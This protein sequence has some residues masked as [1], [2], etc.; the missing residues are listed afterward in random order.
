MLPDPTIARKYPNSVPRERIPGLISD[1]REILKEPEVI[2]ALRD[3]QYRVSPEF[4][5]SSVAGRVHDI[6]KAINSSCKRQIEEGGIVRHLYDSTKMLEQLGLITKGGKHFF[7]KRQGFGFEYFAEDERPHEAAGRLTLVYGYASRTFLYRGTGSLTRE[8]DKLYTVT[9][10]L[11]VAFTLSEGVSIPTS[12]IE[13]G[14]VN[15]ATRAQIHAAYEVLS[16]TDTEA[17]NRSIGKWW[18]D[19]QIHERSLVRSE[20][21][22]RRHSLVLPTDII[23]LTLTVEDSGFERVRNHNPIFFNRH[24]TLDRDVDGASVI[25]LGPQNVPEM[26][27][28]SFDRGDLR[29]QLQRSVDYIAEMILGGPEDLDVDWREHTITPPN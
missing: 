25:F 19:Y 28:I 2:R 5:E 21:K 14:W 13:R 6:Y 24:F 27:R 29:G 23:R 3:D 16:Q 22:V 10:G 9:D 17:E 11:H 7:S 12:I 4:T 18:R 26:R 8:S 20:R 15:G 1:A